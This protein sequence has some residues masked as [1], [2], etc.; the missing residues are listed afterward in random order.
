MPVEPRWT[1]PFEAVGEQH[2][3]GVARR[4]RKLTGERC[5]AGGRNRGRRRRGNRG[6]RRR[7]NRGRR[8]RGNRGRRRRGNRGRRR[9]G[10]RGRRRGEIRPSRV[11]QFGQERTARGSS[12]TDRVRTVVCDDM[13]GS[14]HLRHVGTLL[15]TPGEGPHRLLVDPE[16]GRIPGRVVGDVGAVVLQCVEQLSADRCRDTE[17]LGRGAR[18]EC[19]QRAHP[20]FRVVARISALGPR[21]HQS[22]WPA[23]GS[24]SACCRS[25]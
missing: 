12:T 21:T 7:G 8:R 11:D 18:R 5:G 10:N 9:R 16:I 2:R 25:N 22:H 20:E 14:D 19:K 6:R 15:R 3:A 1:G 4:R 17:A 13:Q 24:Y 23:S